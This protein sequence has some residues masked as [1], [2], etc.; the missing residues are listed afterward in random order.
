V[1]TDPPCLEELWALSGQ[2]LKK[3][4]ELIEVKPFYRLNWPDGTNFDY[5]ND[6]TQLRGEIEKLN[7]AD[8]AGYERFLKYSEGVYREGYVKL[9]SAAFLDFTSM[10]KAA[11]ALAKYQ[12]WRSVYSIVC[13]YVK[14][15]KLREAL[16]FH[17][18][19]VG[20]NPMTT[21]SIYALI[22]KIEKDG[23]VW[24]ARGGTN[25]LVSGMVT[26]FERI[27][28]KVR[29]SAPVAK[30]NTDGNRATGVTLASGEVFFTPMPSSFPTTRADKRPKRA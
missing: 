12:A 18:L 27:G 4:V 15:E 20:G 22:H 30:I 8:V 1:I 24:F 14:D 3:D 7:P 10:I 2:E 29:L 17:T 13:K 16:S 28:G 21:S 19:L 5:S 25:K 6:E 9:G 26:L 23:G 11:P